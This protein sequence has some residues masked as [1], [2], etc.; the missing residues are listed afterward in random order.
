VNSKAVQGYK[1]QMA[2]KLFSFCQCG[3][4]CDTIIVVGDEKSEN[5][6]RGYWTHSAIIASASDVLYAR[7]S[8]V[9]KLLTPQLRFVIHMPKDC[10]PEAVESLLQ[11]LYTGQFKACVSSDVDEEWRDILCV[12]KAF[13]IS[14][15]SFCR[16]Q[17]EEN[18]D[19]HSTHDLQ[20]VLS[21]FQIID[22]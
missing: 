9:S 4:F 3:T 13:G 1:Q 16:G 19:G 12:A 11:F 18:G 6:K 7:L 20:Y 2:R 14:L 21:S 8:A 17:L 15:S 10:T 22:L 5:A